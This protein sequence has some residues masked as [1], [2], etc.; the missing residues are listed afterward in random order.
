MR[1]FIVQN[2]KAK[3]K[4]H[5]RDGYINGAIECRE[6]GSSLGISWYLW[7]SLDRL[8]FCLYSVPKSSCCISLLSGC[9]SHLMH[10]PSMTY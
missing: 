10:T 2:G 4:D 5:V 7:V 1:R 6:E 3:K 9:I 8:M